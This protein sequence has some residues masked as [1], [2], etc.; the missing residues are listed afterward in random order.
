[1][2]G[3]SGMLSRWDDISVMK[4]KLPSYRV[5]GNLVILIL[6]TIMGLVILYGE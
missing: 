6:A 4:F 1:M 2:H 3:V 5:N